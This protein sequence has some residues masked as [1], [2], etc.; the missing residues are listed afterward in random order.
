MYCSTFKTF[1]I[2][3]F[4]YVG[5]L[6]MFEVLFGQRIVRE[7]RLISSLTESCPFALCHVRNIVFRKGFILL[8]SFFFLVCSLTYVPLCHRKKKNANDSHVCLI[9]MSAFLCLSISLRA[10][11][12]VLLLWLHQMYFTKLFLKSQCCLLC[13]SILKEDIRLRWCYVLVL[14]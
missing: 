11:V 10:Q 14:S 7:K 2:T 1:L 4:W 13:F 9:K 8:E 12:F 3:L 6:L 5:R